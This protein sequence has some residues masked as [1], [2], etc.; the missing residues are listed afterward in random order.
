L[1]RYFEIAGG[2]GFPVIA[3]KSRGIDVQHVEFVPMYY[4]QPITCR[5][6]LS[7]TSRLSSGVFL[8]PGISEEENARLV[9]MMP[10]R[11]IT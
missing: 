2:V 11:N 10:S 4:H 9:A 8:S 7:V 6:L 3:C 1:I 5:S